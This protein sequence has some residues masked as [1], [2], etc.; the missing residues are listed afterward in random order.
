MKIKS[1]YQKYHLDE[2]R[3]VSKFKVGDKVQFNLNSEIKIGIIEKIYND[4]N[5]VIVREKYGMGYYLHPKR[6]TKIK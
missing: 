6:L 1:V 4:K 3:S 5:Y 2:F